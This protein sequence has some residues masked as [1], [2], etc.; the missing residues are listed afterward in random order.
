M[1]S[2]GVSACAASWLAFALAGLSYAQTPAAS[3]PQRKLLDQYCV[4][5]HNQRLKTANLMLDKMDVERIA[6]GAEVWEKVVRKIHGGTMPPVGMPRPDQ[7]TLLGFAGWLEA[8]LDRAAANNVNPGRTALHRLNR[9]EYANAIRDLLAL[10]IDSKALLPGDDESNGF[11][12]IADVLKVSPLLLEQYVA[13]SRKV[14]ALAVGDPKTPAVG[15]I[16]RIPPDLSQEQHIEGLPLGTRG[17]VLI[18]HNFPL[19]GDYDFNI[20]LLRNIVGYMPGMEFAHRIEITIDGVRVFSERVGGPEDNLMMDTNL[21]TAGEAIDARLKTRVPVKAGPHAVGFT[22]AQKNLAE[23]DEPLQPFTRDLD[24]Q[25]MN[26]VPLI[27]HVEIAGPFDAKGPG[28]TPSR[29]RIFLCKPGKGIDDLTC[30]RQI[31]TALAKR[32]YR[33]PVAEGDLEELLSFYQTGKNQGNFEAG[34][35]NALRLI[36]ANPKFIFRAETDAGVAAGVVHRINDLELASRLSFFLWSSIPDEALISAAAQGRL[37]DPATLESQVKRMLADPRANAL[38]KNFAGQW[39]FLRNLQS[40]APDGQTFP[41]FDDNLRQAFRSETEMFFSSILREDRSVLDLMT[42]N[43]TFVNERLAKHYGIPNVYGSQ[44]RRVT[45]AD[46]NRWGLLGQG[47]VLTVTSYPNR[48]SAVLRG[49]WILENVLGTPPPAP[50]PNV[51]AL[52]ENGDGKQLSLRQLMEQHRANPACATCHKVMDPLGLALE[53]FDAIGQWRTKEP[54]GPIDAAGQLADG[55]KVTGVA[56]L[57]KALLQHPEQFVGTVTEKMLTYALGRGLEY[58]DMPVVRGIVREAAKSNYR[59]SA[60]V[61]GIVQSPSFEM[62]KAPAAEAS[63][64]AVK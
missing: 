21:G 37:K 51:P 59:F 39:L 34:I 3:A 35:E 11:D 52:K 5:C 61:M 1:K 50:P 20:S 47:S 4:T 36:L 18:H 29:R 42:A 54:A 24:L 14:S 19:D 8:S 9:T 62:R 13:A 60:L 30:A 23:S 27:D 38:V 49:K 10:D 64:A 33:R 32:A 56:D 55:T 22:F 25:N 45:L 48:T 28:D 7:A 31:L 17:G 46:E 41:N 63:L 6:D 2:L 53:N 44:F 26:G 12:N 16:Y 58:Y 40:V 43:Y 57:R 15:Q